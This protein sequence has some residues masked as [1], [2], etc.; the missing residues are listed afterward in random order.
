MNTIYTNKDDVHIKIVQ[1]DPD[2]PIYIRAHD[3][4]EMLVPNKVF[5][6]LVERFADVN[7]WGNK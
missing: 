5:C 4:R 2:M 6:E 3:G 1:T 7:D